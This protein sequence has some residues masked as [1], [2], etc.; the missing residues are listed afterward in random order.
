LNASAG[1]GNRWAGDHIF[2]DNHDDLAMI[3]FFFRFI[4]LLCLALAFVLLVY[5]GTKSIADQTFYVTSV[6]AI[7]SNVHQSSLSALQPAVEKIMG[8]APWRSVI[9]PYVLDAPMWAAL[10]ILGAILILFGR[11]KRKLIGYARD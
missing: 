9:K 1:K 6:E 7:W 11:K 2:F 4:G 5:D 8:P 3:R 10:G